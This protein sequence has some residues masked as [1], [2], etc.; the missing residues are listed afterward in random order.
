MKKQS[1]FRFKFVEEYNNL[2]KYNKDVDLSKDHLSHM[3]IHYL[4]M[5]G[6][7][8]IKT[9]KEVKT[10]MDYYQSQIQNYWLSRS[11]YNKGLMALFLTEIMTLIPLLKF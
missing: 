10:I 1:V 5:R 9:S 8:E 11:L 4:Y 2:T 6:F 3:Q 7:S